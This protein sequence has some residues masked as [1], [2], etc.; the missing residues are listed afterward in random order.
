[1]YELASLSKHRGCYGVNQPER[2]ILRYGQMSGHHG[3]LCF[4]KFGEEMKH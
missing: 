4:V 3:G 1:L 2:T